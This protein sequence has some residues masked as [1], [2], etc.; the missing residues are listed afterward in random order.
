MTQ[1]VTI[2]GIHAVT[3]LLEHAPKRAVSLHVLDAKKSDRVDTVLRLAKKAAV[4]VNRVNQDAFTRLLDD[5]QALHQGVLLR[6]QPFPGFRESDLLALLEVKRSEGHKATVLVLDGVQDPRNLGA[7]LRSAAAFCVDAVVLPK[8]RSAALTATAEKVACGGA[9]LVPIVTVTNV[10][11]TL[12]QLQEAGLWVV[13][14][15]GDAAQP[16]GAIDL[17]TDT[18]LVMGNEGIGMRRLTEKHCDFLAKIPMNGGIS[19]LNVSAATT[20]ALYELARQRT[21]S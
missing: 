16:L 20:V 6:C 7:C 21:A 13:G 18:V 1:H 19:S 10:S 9:A 12:K 4:S 8:D 11:R 14:L 3:H 2:Y 15:S 5:E 17:K